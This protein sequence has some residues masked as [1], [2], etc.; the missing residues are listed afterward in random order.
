MILFSSRMLGTDRLGVRGSVL[1]GADSP[2]KASTMVRVP[3]NR[4]FCCAELVADEADKA[5]RPEMD[6]C[7][8]CPPNRDSG[9]W[10]LEIGAPLSDT[11][12]S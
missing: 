3:M 7:A 11:V 5:E 8:E 6:D 4:R 9:L 10:N 1:K 12:S 2:V